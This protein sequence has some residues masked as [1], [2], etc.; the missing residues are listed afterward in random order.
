MCAVKTVCS[1]CYNHMVQLCEELLGVYIYG[2]MDVPV[3]FR[4]LTKDQITV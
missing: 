2:G 4:L 3:L 1:P